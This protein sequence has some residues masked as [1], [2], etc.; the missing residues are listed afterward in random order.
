MQWSDTG[1]EIYDWGRPHRIQDIAV[2]PDGNRLVAMDHETHIYV[3]NFM[4]REA[5]YN[6]DLE[7]KLTSVSISNDSRYL[8][9][10]RTDGHVKLW[11]LEMR[12]VVRTFKG[13]KGG[14]FV[15]RSSFGGANESFV[16]SGSE[17]T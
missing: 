16:V 11:D 4:T 12:G 5:E 10:G 7:V 6:F 3:Y 14:D 13:A 1:D 17:G 15:I 8:L 9:V 2:S